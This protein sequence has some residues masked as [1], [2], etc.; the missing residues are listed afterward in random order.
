MRA[1]KGRSPTAISARPA[2]RSSWRRQGFAGSIALTKLRLVAVAYSKFLINVPLSDERLRAMHYSVEAMALFASPL[3]PHY[4][5]L[6]GQGRSS[7]ASRRRRRS[8][9]WSYCRSRFRDEVPGLKS[10]IRDA[11]IDWAERYKSDSKISNPTAANFIRA[12]LCTRLIIF[13]ASADVLRWLM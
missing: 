7:I 10:Q 2:R 6:I 9:C 1:S 12:S 11:A 5:M 3:M 8:V 4:F 13:A